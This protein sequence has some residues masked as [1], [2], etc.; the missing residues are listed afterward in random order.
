MTLLI[1]PEG[2]LIISV[3]VSSILYFLEK[4]YMILAVGNGGCHE[5]L[6]PPT[7]KSMG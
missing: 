3:R 5:A 2:Y 4:T 1:P 7:V 6:S